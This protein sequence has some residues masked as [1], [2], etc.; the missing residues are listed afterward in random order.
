MVQ[1]R[2]TQQASLVLGAVF[3]WSLRS[4]NTTFRQATLV[5]GCDFK[6]YTAFDGARFLDEA[7]FGAL[8]A[9][10]RFDFDRVAF[11]SRVPSFVQANFARPPRLDNAEIPLPRFF[12]R[13]NP[14]HIA[15]YRALRRI[16]NQAQDFENKWRAFKGEMRASRGNLQ[17]PWDAG[18]WESLIYDA[19][20]DD[21]WS[22]M[23]PFLIWLVSIVAFA[24]AYLASAGRLAYLTDAGGVTGAYAA[25]QWLNA[26]LLSAKN[27]ILFVGLDRNVDVQVACLYGAALPAWSAFIFM[28]QNVFSVLLI[29]YFCSRYG[30]SSRSNEAAPNAAKPAREVSRRRRMPQVT[31]ETAPNHAVVAPPSRCS[32]PHAR[33]RPATNR[34]VI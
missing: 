6:S 25:P 5:S 9:P 2:D 31:A 10:G 4:H 1:Q 18:F 26:L 32:M 33:L 19:L 7:D 30:T 27:A 28:A 20:A 13:T 14:R 24:A 3:A 22:T 8:Q 17:K 29:S 12:A 34:V 23:R 21:G 16:A 11:A 15:S